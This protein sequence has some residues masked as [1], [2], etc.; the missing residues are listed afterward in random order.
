MKSLLSA[1][2]RALDES[3]FSTAL[4]KCNQV[5]DL[6]P[7][8]YHAHLFK[9]FVFSKTG[10]LSDAIVEFEIAVSINPES[11]LA[12][13]GLISST[14]NDPLMLVSYYKRLAAIHAK[15]QPQKYYDVLLKMIQVY[16]AL[17]DYD[18]VIVIWEKMLHRSPEYDSLKGFIQFSSTEIWE[19]IL[20][21]AVAKDEL[22]YEKEWQIQKFRIQS[23]A[24]DL[25]KKDIE[26]QVNLS[27]KVALPSVIKGGGSNRKYSDSN[28]KE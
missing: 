26:K 13:Q 8:N 12:Y 5:I 9:G 23:K 4:E 7:T 6:E 19:F 22:H 1:A 24:M 10:N 25:V 21:A 14:Q 3:D 27:S 17:N 28:S 20:R 2:R 15:D 11:P 16:T 18:S